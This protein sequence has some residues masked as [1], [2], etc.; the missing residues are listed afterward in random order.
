[1]PVSCFSASALQHSD[2]APREVDRFPASSASLRDDAEMQLSR[3][4]ARSRQEDPKA[5]L[6]VALPGPQMGS[7]LAQYALEDDPRLAGQ[8]GMPAAQRALLE[9]YA[10]RPPRPCEQPGLQARV[11]VDVQHDRGRDRS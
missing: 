6:R 9:P 7:N 8:R 5:S 3:S 11:A 4:L 1:M 10:Q 2:E